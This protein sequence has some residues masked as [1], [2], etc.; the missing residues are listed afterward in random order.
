MKRKIAA[1]G[2][3]LLVVFQVIAG[4]YAEEWVEFEGRPE[5][6]RDL[7]LAGILS[8]PKG[9]GPF[10]AV[11]M[12]CGCAGLRDKNDAKQQNAWAERLTSWGYASLRV[13]SF[14]PPSYDNICDNLYEVRPPQR[15][16]DAY[17][18]KSFLAGLELVDSNRIAVIGWS[19]GGTAV[20]AAVDGMLR[21]GD[22]KPF[23]AAIAFYPVKDSK[24]EFKLIIYPDAH[25][26][27]DFEGLKGDF[28]GHHAESNPEAAADAIQ[29]TEDFLAKYL[30]RNP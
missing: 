12:L 4:A 26:S 24:S 9:D 21:D 7:Q 10:P 23:Q 16:K 2:I 19:H 18:A 29:Q 1:R 17:S 8:V 30:G 15:A 20:M 3:V 27:F 6:G 28:Y 14:G 11:V 5:A 22:A 25:H 13:D